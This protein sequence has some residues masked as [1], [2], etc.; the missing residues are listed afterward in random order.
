M[1]LVTGLVERV[2]H[3]I[4]VK[5][6][7][8]LCIFVGLLDTGEHSDNGV[9]RVFVML[10]DPYAVTRSAH[11]N[12]HCQA[13][14]HSL[15]LAPSVSPHQLTCLNPIKNTMRTPTEMS[16]MRT[17]LRRPLAAMTAPSSEDAFFAGVDP[18]TGEV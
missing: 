15:G 12:P 14:W 11:Q 1:P 16:T 18:E 10:D 7:D 3:P 2:D 5:W 4:C 6:P 8:S 9:V 13:V 17:A